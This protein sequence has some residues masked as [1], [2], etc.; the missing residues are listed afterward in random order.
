MTQDK[1]DQEIYQVKQQIIKLE[2]TY[3]ELNEAHQNINESFALLEDMKPLKQDIEHYVSKGW[4]SEA[5]HQF[6]SQM[7][8]DWRHEE[9]TIYQKLEDRTAEI[10]LEKRKNQEAKETAERTLKQIYQKEAGGA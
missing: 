2:D 6:L 4:R 9:R 3:D 1:I 7:S 10:Q 8:D 5:S